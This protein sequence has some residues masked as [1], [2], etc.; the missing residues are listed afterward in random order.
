MG[1]SGTKKGGKIPKPSYVFKNTRSILSSIRGSKVNG[2]IAANTTQVDISEQFR[3]RL[4]IE[5]TREG[6][7]QGKLCS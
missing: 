2:K 6:N 7:S 4:S 5:R 3:S 1:K